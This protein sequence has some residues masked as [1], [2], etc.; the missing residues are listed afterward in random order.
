MFDVRL[1]AMAAWVPSFEISFP[2]APGPARDE[3]MEQI[4]RLLVFAMPTKEERAAFLA[5]LGRARADGFTE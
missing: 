4:A 3:A 1:Q 2:T 5:D